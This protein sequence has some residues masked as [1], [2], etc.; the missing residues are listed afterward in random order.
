MEMR[1]NKVFKNGM[2]GIAYRFLCIIL[3]FVGRTF[4]IRYLS[5]EYLGISGLF[6]NVLSILSLS[7]L[8]FSSAV[9]YHL[10]RLLAKKD[11]AQIA[12]LMNFYKNVYRI[13]AV[14][15]LV[16][17]MI[18][19][20]F[21]RYIIKESPFS[22]RYVSIVYVIY[23]LKTV[24]SYLYSYN[25]TIATAD[26]KSYIL[27]RVDIIVHITVSIVNILTLALFRN[28][29]IYLVVEI[30]ITVLGSFIKS[31]R[32]RKRYPYIRLKNKID[33]A[34][35]KKVMK[36]V[37]N[38]F[39]EKMATVVVTATDN[40]IISA[41]I[42]I[43]VVGL[44]SNYSMIIMN[45]QM[46][47][48]QF[49]SATQSSLGNM[50]AF[51]SKE[52]SYSILKKLTI[53]LYFITCF[54]SVCLFVLLNP[55]IKI[56]LGP[57]YLLG[58]VVVALCVLN[59]YVQIVKTPLW[60]SVTGVGYFAKD[61]NIAIYGAVSNLVVSII[62]AHFW[63]LAGV[64]FGTAFSQ[65][66]QWIFKCRLFVGK[67]LGK[68][69][70][71]F[72][73]ISIGLLLLMAGMCAGIYF[74]FEL[75]QI[76]N[77]YLDLILRLVACLIIPNVLNVLIFRKTE[78]F[79]YLKGLARRLFA[80]FLKKGGAVKTSSQSTEQKSSSNDAVATCTEKNKSE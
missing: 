70:W 55:F 40:I 74:A 19:L 80:K 32:V 3:S 31:L 36:D 22:L 27:T 77:P 79:K 39:A 14:V 75:F 8:G 13:V 30:G 67:Y 23:L 6:T 63:G 46:L 44:Y 26:Q 72:F 33:K 71:E 25:F 56:W 7:E 59:F 53:I 5:K 45:V 52:Y 1:A 49:T 47:L 2:W 57:Q 11:E 10:Y 29:I 42:S 20:P 12:G 9:S 60:F 4:F 51:E 35:K 58:V 62:C 15:V 68:K 50:L 78:A 17:G 38:I 64:F 65:L 76:A 37:T 24:V 61:R 66:T 34:T 21:L 41:M 73:F 16:A 48:T 43:G 69:I 28:F 54:C 18:V